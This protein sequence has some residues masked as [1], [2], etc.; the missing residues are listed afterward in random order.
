MRTLA[1]SDRLRGVEIA[2]AA[3]VKPPSVRVYLARLAARGMVEATGTQ[4][5]R[6]WALTPS[7]RDLI[8]VRNSRRRL[9]RKQS[10]GGRCR[11]ATRSK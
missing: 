8:G 7:G 10:K 4:T 1:T 11:G 5:M 6:L 9:K 2:T 3:G